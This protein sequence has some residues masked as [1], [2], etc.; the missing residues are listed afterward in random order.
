MS[1]APLA[2][3]CHAS[4]VRET[5][6][7]FFTPAYTSANGKK[8][9]TCKICSKASH[10]ASLVAEI[11]TLRRHLE[12]YHKAEYLQW[13]EANGFTSMLPKDAKQRMNKPSGSKQG[14]LDSYIQPTSVKEE[15]TGYSDKLFHEALVRW[16][17]ETD[18]PLS[19]VENPYFKNMIHAASS[20]ATNDDDVTTSD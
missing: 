10:P 16:I 13:A 8:M 6:I 18:Q 20:C 11:S 19:V 1:M 4:T 3:P 5:S 2:E 15:A 7:S 9:R 12:S 14:R 17:V